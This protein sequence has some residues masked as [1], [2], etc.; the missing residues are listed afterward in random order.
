MEVPLGLCEKADLVALLAGF[1]TKTFPIVREVGFVG[2]Q[3]AP[4]VEPSVAGMSGHLVDGHTGPPGLCEKGDLQ[5]ISSALS[6]ETEGR[7]GWD[8][9]S[10]EEELQQS[11]GG[12]A[13]RTSMEP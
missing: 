4:Q 2:A 5:N 13:L 6:E 10:P 3:F 12:A 9:A 8:G 11:R 7:S 1:A